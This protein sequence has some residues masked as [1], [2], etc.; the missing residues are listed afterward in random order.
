MTCNPAGYPL[1]ASGPV[2]G[3]GHETEYHFEYD[4]GEYWSIGLPQR[5]EPADAGQPEPAIK[6]TI[7]PYYIMIERQGQSWRAYQHISSASIFRLMR[8]ITAN[9]YKAFRKPPET[10]MIFHLEVE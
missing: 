5:Y 3:G 1:A 7:Q 4:E 10:T 2:P 9:E 8:V 6:I